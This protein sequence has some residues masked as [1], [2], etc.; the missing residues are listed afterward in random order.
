MSSN[1]LSE[2]F[3]GDKSPPCGDMSPLCGDVSTLCGNMPS[4]CNESPPCGDTST[5]C[6]DMYLPCDRST[7]C[8]GFPPCDDMSSLCVGVLLSQ[9]N[10]RTLYGEES[11]LDYGGF[12]ETGLYMCGD[13][14]LTYGYKP[15][16]IAPPVGD[17]EDCEKFSTQNSRNYNPFGYDSMDPTLKRKLE[18]IQ[19]VEY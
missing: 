11:P 14:V 17:Y 4:S 19:G 1:I 3:C 15:A 16:V 18:S 6:S 12:S 13:I 2:C 7:S 10:E 9:E 5:P 8:E